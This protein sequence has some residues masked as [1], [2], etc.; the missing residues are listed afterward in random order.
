MI[1][2][3]LLSLSA[4]L[5][6]AGLCA[7]AQNETIHLTT[8]G[9]L[10]SLVNK[11]D[12]SLAV[13]GNIDARDFV[14][15]RDSMPNLTHV[16]LSGANIVGYIGTQGTD[17][18]TLTY[19]DNE[20][21]IGAFGCITYQHITTIS[22]PPVVTAIGL[23]AFCFC[24]YINS[25]SIPAST[26]FI[27]T[28]AFAACGAQINVD[29]N[30]AFYSSIDG[31]LFNKAQ[32]TLIS[33]PRSKT[34][35]YVVPNTVKVI[36]YNSFYL[37]QIDS[38]NIPTS[39]SVLGPDAFYNCSLTSCTLPASVTYI[40]EDVFRYCPYNCMLTFIMTLLAV[41]IDL[42]NIPQVFYGVYT[43]S[44][45][46][47]VPY[48]CESAYQSANQWKD[49]THIIGMDGFWVSTHNVLL[50]DAG[51]IDSITVK[52]NVSWS[53][54]SNQSWL[55]ISNASGTNNGTIIITAE[56]NSNGTFR[57]AE[58]T[59]AANGIPSQTIIVVQ[60][61][62]VTVSAG[63]L[64]SLLSPLVKNSINTL[65]I[66]GTIDARD[67]VTMR[68]SM[69]NLANIDLSKATIV[70]YDGYDGTDWSGNYEDYPANEIPV[71]AFM[72]PS[73]GTGVGKSSPQS[74]VLSNSDTAIAGGAFNGCYNLNAITI[75]ASITS[76]G[77]QS[78]SGFINVE[79][80]NP[81]Y[82]SIDGVLYDKAQDTLIQCPTS[83]TGIF[84]IPNTVKVID[85]Y[86]F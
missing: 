48:G 42:T 60:G 15:M 58:V 61:N 10:D 56:A 41:P 53:V 27:G 57:V 44:C 16:D 51:G 34:G 43:N 80:S 82:S 76:I 28:D 31:V 30:N 69:P 86:A 8:A 65:V 84:T 1:M 52:A 63:N 2:K 81:N 6:I 21:P 3:K 74:I 64:N 12:T 68:D 45:K 25:I 17:P 7:V 26:T 18:S 54:S 67:F 24:N 50:P 46:L 73:I 4:L 14:T 37:C 23:N 59:V 40:G 71:Y 9:T 5:L 32:D 49:F 36:G 55:T 39:V 20:I 38:I 29:A 19:Y 85:D 11:S 33:C 75:P 62:T 78:S 66:T 22:L 47:Y 70:D 72:N 13:T 79:A 35:T 83:K 77:H